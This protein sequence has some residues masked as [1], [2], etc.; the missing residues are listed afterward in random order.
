MNVLC[1]YVQVVFCMCPDTRLSSHEWGGRPALQP[2]LYTQ[3]IWSLANS[4]SMPPLSGIP[5]GEQQPRQV[6]Q[7]HRCWEHLCKWKVPWRQLGPEGSGVLAAVAS[8]VAEPGTSQKV[9]LSAQSFQG[10]VRLCVPVPHPFPVCS[11]DSWAWHDAQ[12]RGAPLI[13]GH[14]IILNGPSVWKCAWA[15]GREGSVR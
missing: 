12:H 9:R 5:R 4:P 8:S 2:H 6:S 1:S 10:W 13:C 3:R 15:T 11:G 7:C 14:R